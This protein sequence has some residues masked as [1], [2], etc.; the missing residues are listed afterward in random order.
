MNT[1]I[2]TWTNN[3]FT[4]RLLEHHLRQSQV[5]SDKESQAENEPELIDHLLDHKLDL[6]FNRQL[7][8]HRENEAFAAVFTRTIEILLPGFLPIWKQ[9]IGLEE[10][11]YLAQTVL[12]L[13]LENFFL[14]ITDET[15]NRSWITA[16]FDQIREMVR[17]F[18]QNQ[19]ILPVDG[20]V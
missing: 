19:A 8:V 13:S 6:L 14:Q 16:D 15:L 20:T 9:I 3:H 18:K 2:N 4:E 10:H 17:L 11:N 1:S 7:R 5:L 12:M